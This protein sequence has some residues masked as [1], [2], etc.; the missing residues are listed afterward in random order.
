M[1]DIT[2]EKKTSVQFRVND[3]EAATIRDI[4]KVDALGPAALSMI[5][6]DIEVYRANAK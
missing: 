1:N 3:E 5:R 6:H 2:E 4:T